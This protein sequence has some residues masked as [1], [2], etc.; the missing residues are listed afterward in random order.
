MK[1]PV[2]RP[3]ARAAPWIVIAA[4]LPLACGRRGAPIPPRRVA[5][6]A[7][8]SFRAGP[9]DT[10]ILV[11]WVRPVRNED[12]SPLTDLRE[13]RLYRAVGAP[14]PAGTA[15]RP[16]FSLLATIRA[17]QPDNAIVQDNQYAFRDNGGGA[18]F[19][20]DTRYSYR[21][22]A[23]NR[24]GVVGRSSPDAVVDFSPPPGPPT[25]LQVTAGDG[26]VDL[27]WKAPAGGGPA[28]SPPLRGYNLYR[29]VQPQTYGI[30]PINAAPVI[31]TRFRDAGLANET[32]YYYVVR[33]VAGER[34]P[35]RESANSN[36]ISAAPMDLTPP[37]P[38]RGLV[39]V[40][41]TGT[42]ALSWDINPEA[43]LLGYF[44]YRREPPALIPA[45]LTEAP[46]Q[47]TTFTDR[48]A[49][50]RVSY[51]YSVT[52]VD[53]SPRRNESAPSAEAPATLP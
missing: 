14:A 38:P 29:G 37:A 26:A 9:R 35:W 3:L 34:P 46:I 49:R 53:R 17:E 25:A 21:V 30:Q 31:D 20:R 50:P 10:D 41:A 18:G 51:L 47:S 52:A 13:F 28:G 39:A 48:T 16:T 19:L 6:A 8:E 22:Q 42:I 45:R 12:G 7:V 44:V 11:S 4:L 24:R 43:D 33:S 5:P 2:R 32:T 40:A 36:E 23:V 1:H 27:N 15:E